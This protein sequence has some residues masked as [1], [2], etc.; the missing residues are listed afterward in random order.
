MRFASVLMQKPADILMQMP[1]PLR[2][3]KE[4]QW[5]HRGEEVTH[6][7]VRRY[8]SQHLRWSEDHGSY[9]VAEGK[10]CVAVEIEDTFHVIRSIDTSAHPWE[11]LLDTDERL[12]LDAESI[13]VSGEHVLYAKVEGYDTAFRLL[14]PAFQAV[15]PFIEEQS[16][17]VFVLRVGTE[18]FQ[19][20]EKKEESR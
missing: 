8:F 18:R 7:G 1:G 10:K 2:F 4:G 13:C 17:G 14:R 3:T 6:E 19:V 9:V 20:K 11:A 16:E 12:A 15:L 5:T